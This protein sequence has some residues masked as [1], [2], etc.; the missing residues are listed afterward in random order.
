MKMKVSGYET[1]RLKDPYKYWS[2]L[3]NS[4]PGRK[5]K[6]V[7]TWTY[8]SRIDDATL[9]FY[10][11]HGSTKHRLC[12]LNAGDIW[13][14]ILPSKDLMPGLGNRIYELTE[15]TVGRDKS[16]HRQYENQVRVWFHPRS[17]VRFWWDRKDLPYEPGVEIRKGKVL[18]PEKYVDKKRRV[19]D[20]EKADAIKAKLEKIKE[21]APIMVRLLQAQHNTLDD[22]PEGFS[23]Q[24]RQE[25]LAN[26]DPNNVNC[27][28]AERVFLWGRTWTGRQQVPIY[29]GMEWSVFHQKMQRRI[30]GYRFETDEEFGRRCVV[31]G[32]RKLREHVYS[33][34]GVYQYE[35]VA[36]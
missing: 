28:D 8:V 23:V 7:A 16:G 9:E 18:N 20:T 27:L 5:R 26:F 4:T 21:L 30:T 32:L 14:V 25:L 3:L 35:P 11:E 33:K 10:Y 13:T 15:V 36:N 2:R 34:E 12:L 6:C 22:I 17:G 19:A 1:H 29:N 31:N 24:D